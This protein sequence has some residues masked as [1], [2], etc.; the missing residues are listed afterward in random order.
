MKA[1]IISTVPSLCS[2]SDSIRAAKTN[3]D[4]FLLRVDKTSADGG[5]KGS[6]EEIDSSALTFFQAKTVFNL[7]LAQFDRLLNTDGV[8]LSMATR[9]HF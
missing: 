1:S 5:A 4:G 7:R 8:F 2:L 9:R 3:A 6:A